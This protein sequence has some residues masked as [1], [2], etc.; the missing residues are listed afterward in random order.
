M[1]G[2]I[3]CGLIVVSLCGISGGGKMK[4]E[5]RDGG[6]RR[7]RAKTSAKVHKFPSALGKRFG[8]TEGGGAARRDPPSL[9]L[10]RARARP[11]IRLRNGAVGRPAPNV[12][13]EKINFA[14]RTQV[15]GIIYLR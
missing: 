2:S 13:G 3:L 8:D 10:R 12:G 14:K 1:R 11:P 7:G 6:G 5:G 4:T 15:L 9:K